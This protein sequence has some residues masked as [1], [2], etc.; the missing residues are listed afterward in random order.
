M[1]ETPTVKLNGRLWPRGAQ[2]HIKRLSGRGSLRGTGSPFWAR[3]RLIWLHGDAQ[4]GTAGFDSDVRG[5]G[6][7]LHRSL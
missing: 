7:V 5:A 6:Q 1:T 4:L 2:S 3:H